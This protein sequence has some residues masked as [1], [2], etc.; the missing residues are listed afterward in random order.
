MV[1]MDDKYFNYQVFPDSRCERLDDGAYGKCPFD[2]I[3]G[4]TSNLYRICSSPE[5][6]IT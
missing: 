5:M 1:K 2:V 3:T 4:L 6:I